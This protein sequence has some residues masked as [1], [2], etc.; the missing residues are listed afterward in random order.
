[1]RKVTG[2]SSRSLVN[3]CSLRSRNNILEVADT[4]WV[5]DTGPPSSH[6]WRPCTPPRVSKATQSKDGMYFPCRGSH[7]Y[8]GQCQQHREIPLIIRGRSGKKGQKRAKKS[9]NRKRKKGIFGFSRVFR[10][11]TLTWK[12]GL[13]R[14]CYPSS[15]HL[16]S[17]FFSVARRILV[18]PS[19]PATEE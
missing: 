6:E 3:L 9:R 17:F 18:S 4:E 19:Q 11:Q 12:G 1:V 10:L 15:S 14:M 16:K 7:P 5:T 8:P 2:L 13:L